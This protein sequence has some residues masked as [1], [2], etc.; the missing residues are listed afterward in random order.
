MPIIKFKTKEEVPEGLKAEE[1]D[2]AFVVDVVEKAK[3]DE[4]RDNNIALS[5]ERD[6]YKNKASFYESIAGDDPEKF[7]GELE[8]LRKT[9]QLV[10]DGK[11]KGSSAVDE[12]VNRRVT[13]VKEGYDGQIRDLSTKLEKANMRADTAEGRARRSVVTNAVTQAILDPESGVNPAASKFVLEQAY[14]LFHVDE[15]ENLIPKKG[16]AVQYGA[17]GVSPMTPK[18]WLQK[19]LV[20]APYFSLKS[21]GGGASGN[22]DSKLPGGFSQESWDKLSPQERIK[23]ARKAQRA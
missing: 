2:G 8:D 13:S 21:S 17:D 20:D 11:L 12:E 5:K 14:G 16:D 1:K 9:D 3:L 19:L 10:K 4:F 18:E 6:T 7:K 23:E 15:N 22:G